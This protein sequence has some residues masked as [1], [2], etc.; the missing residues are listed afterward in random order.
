MGCYG[1]GVYG[2]CAGNRVCKVLK[3]HRGVQCRKYKPKKCCHTKCCAKK[4]QCCGRKRLYR[5]KYEFRHR[6]Y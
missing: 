4:K 5:S 2:G 3:L 1:C 6:I